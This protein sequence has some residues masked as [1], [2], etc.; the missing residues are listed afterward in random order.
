MPHTTVTLLFCISTKDKQRWMVG[1]LRPG[2]PKISVT[3]LLT[4][5]KQY[6]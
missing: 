3:R 1:K 6:R 2:E 4:W 5:K